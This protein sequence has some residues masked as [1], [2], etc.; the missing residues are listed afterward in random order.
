MR[1]LQTA[2]CRDGQTRDQG[3]GQ[4]REAQSN[5]LRAHRERQRLPLGLRAEHTDGKGQT[6][7]RVL[8]DSVF[9]LHPPLTGDV[10]ARRTRRLRDDRQGSLSRP[11]FATLPRHFWLG[12]SRRDGGAK[13][14]GRRTPRGV[15][16][17]SEMNYRV[18]CRLGTT[19][20]QAGRGRRARPLRPDLG[21]Q[22]ASARL[23]LQVEELEANAA[24]AE[25]P[26]TISGHA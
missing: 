23:K 24:E 25:A 13:G 5:W 6:R 14:D 15:R 8:V 16:E 17:D 4:G 12:C 1:C 2:V 21:A 22:S 11:S 3:A 7:Y 18:G 20:L 26:A 10:R 9:L 19:R